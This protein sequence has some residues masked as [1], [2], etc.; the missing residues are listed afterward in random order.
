VQRGLPVQKLVRH[1]GREGLSWRISEALRSMVVFREWNLLSDLRRLGE[2]DIVFCR[3]VLIYFDRPT[4][5]RVLE[6]IAG[7]LAPDG[8]LYLG[9]TET[10]IGLSDQWTKTGQPGVYAYRGLTSCRPPRELQNE[11]IALPVG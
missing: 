11:Q 1:F 3:N 9:G 8:L 2:F 10:L 4:R 7:Q 6:A 5:R